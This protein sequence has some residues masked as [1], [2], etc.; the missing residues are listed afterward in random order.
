VVFGEVIEGL[1]VVDL[2]QNVQVDRAKNSRP[3]TSNEVEVIDCGQL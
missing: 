3:L 1:A 2:M